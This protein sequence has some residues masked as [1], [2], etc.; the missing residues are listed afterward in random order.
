VSTPPEKAGSSIPPEFR[1]AVVSGV[2]LGVVAALVVWWLER[3]ELKRGISEVENYLRKH[4]DF[5]SYLRERGSD[6]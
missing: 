1:N 2:V 5:Q 4:S 6:Q 3:F